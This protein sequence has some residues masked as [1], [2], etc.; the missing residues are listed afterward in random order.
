[1]TPHDSTRC[2]KCGCRMLDSAHVCDPTA[3]SQ[4]KVS[5]AP[6]PSEPVGAVDAEE[7]VRI[8]CDNHQKFYESFPEGSL[9][10]NGLQHIADLRYLLARATPAEGEAVAWGIWHSNGDLVGL[11]LT[12]WEAEKW[13]GDSATYGPPRPLYTT[14]PRSPATV[15]EGW[16]EPTAEEL[17]MVQA[18]AHNW[19]IDLNRVNPLMLSLH[20]KL[21]YA[22]TGGR[23]AE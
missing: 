17:E 13:C 16:E 4:Y 21:T 8:Y 22:L 10:T 11:K 2:A 23:D 19:E 1:M 15:T 7:R 18:L 20:K 12:K 9:R 5:A 14:P 3:G 6:R